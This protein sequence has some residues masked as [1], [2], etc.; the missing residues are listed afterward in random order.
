[1]IGSLVVVLP[2]QHEGGSTV[3]VGGRT[4]VLRKCIG[5]LVEPVCGRTEEVEKYMAPSDAVPLET[6][7]MIR[8]K[9][10]P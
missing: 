10:M 5:K 7:M 9:A 8:L 2:I 6:R 1:M 4:C 3:Y